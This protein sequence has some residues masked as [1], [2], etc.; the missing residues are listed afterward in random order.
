MKKQTNKEKQ[1]QKID[2]YKIKLKGK[3]K[4]KAREKRT[5]KKRVFGG[6]EKVNATR[7]IILYSVCVAHA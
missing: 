7:Q 3:K 6:R 5:K 4:K 2:H 1:P